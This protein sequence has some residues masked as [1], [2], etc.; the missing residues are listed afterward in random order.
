M[1]EP[2]FP[3]EFVQKVCPKVK[4]ACDWRAQFKLPPDPEDDEAHAECAFIRA[5]AGMRCENCDLFMTRPTLNKEPDTT[6]LERIEQYYRELDAWEARNDPPPKVITVNG[7]HFSRVEWIE[8]TTQK[9]DESTLKHAHRVA[10][11]LGVGCVTSQDHNLRG[12]YDA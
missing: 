8:L 1:N 10:K 2:Q 9:S 11:G 6:W 3:K 7:R 4:E 12:D 5:G